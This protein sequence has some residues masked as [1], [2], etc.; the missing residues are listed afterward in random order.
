MA[1]GGD[2]LIAIDV[3]VAFLQELSNPAALHCRTRLREFT[4]DVP[5]TDD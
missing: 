1:L 3:D 2:D 5:L 4:L